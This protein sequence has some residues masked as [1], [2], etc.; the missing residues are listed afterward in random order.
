MS[1]QRNTGQDPVNESETVRVE[2]GEHFEVTV[3]DLPGA[4]YEW[5]ASDLPDGLTEVGEDWAEPPP[6][7]V[8]A[9]RR[10]TFRF[11]ADHPGTHLLVVELRRPWERD[12]PPARTRTVEVQVEDRARS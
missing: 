11:R 4:G 5:I 7:L 2:V 3:A 8:G 10:R 6:E 1:G 9:S 12:R